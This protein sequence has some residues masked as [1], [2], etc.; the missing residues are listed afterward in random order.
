MATLNND[1]EKYLRGELTPAERHAL[2]QK[3]LRDPFLA[4]ALEGAE[5]A[6]AENFSLDLELLQRSIKQKSRKRLPKTIT[7]NGWGLYAGI[8]AGLLLLTVSTYIIFLSINQHSKKSIAMM[9]SISI[10]TTRKYQQPKT[11]TDSLIALNTPAEK[12]LTEAK[13][14]RQKGEATS[15]PDVSSGTGIKGSA[16]N[17][18]NFSATDDEQNLA[19]SEE[20]TP[21]TEVSPAGPIVTEDEAKIYGYADK[22]SS[23]SVRADLGVKDQLAKSESAKINPTVVL[24]GKV[25]GV[26]VSSEHI[27][28]GIVTAD[29]QPLPGVN[30]LLK[31]TAHGTVTDVEGNFMISTPGGEHTLL[32]GFI[33]YKTEEIKVWKDEEV[34]VNLREDMTALSEVVVTGYGQQ[35]SYASSPPEEYEFTAP[36]E[37]HVA[38]KEYLKKQMQYPK[39]AL[40]NKV[41]GK[42]T[43]QF[44]VEPNGELTEFNVIKGIGFGCDEELIRLIKQGP[45]WIPSKRNGSAVRER[46]KVRLRFQLPK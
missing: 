19:L 43:V 26:S 25:A 15:K 6:G 29:G 14:E 18:A 34:T 33:G 45:R 4:E 5:H 32:I 44:V 41:E 9:E 30:V 1:I 27:I 11:F 31:G 2:E 3:A 8:A 36:E 38:Y 13:S 28:H 40:D 16:K 20:T 17:G 10:D 46:V 35:R 42:V 23:D 21:N 22:A 7:L 37:G 24:Q 39:E 12:E